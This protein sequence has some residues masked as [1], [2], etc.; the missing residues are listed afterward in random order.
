LRYS[1][2][3]PTTA[4]T[5]GST[6]RP[7]ARLTGDL[8]RRSEPREAGSGRVSL[9]ASRSRIP[10]SEGG[11]VLPARAA[12]Q[13]AFPPNERIPEVPQATSESLP[14][15]VDNIAHVSS[16]VTAADVT[17]TARAPAVRWRTKKRPA[18]RVDSGSL[19]LPRHVRA[20]QATSISRRALAYRNA[21]AFGVAVTFS[22]RLAFAHAC[23]ES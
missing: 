1:T 14:I 9:S 18:R 17:R 15:L 4:A 20:T 5:I 19:G 6:S 10:L 13:R 7:C 2:Q 12:A 21:S 23:E 16:P 11:S 8:Q 3:R 22:S